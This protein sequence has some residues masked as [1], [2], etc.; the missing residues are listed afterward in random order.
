MVARVKMRHGERIVKSEESKLLNQSDTNS[1]SSLFTLHS[2]LS[3]TLP[4]KAV[5]QSSDK[6]LF[7][8][9]VKDGKAHRQS[10]TIGQMVGNRVVIES[11]L[12]EGDQVIVEGYQKVGEG[13][14]VKN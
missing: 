14:P 1:N 8:W 12:S 6:Q 10:V 13:T 3:I 7:V 4:V 5:Q 2:S 11:G 9:V